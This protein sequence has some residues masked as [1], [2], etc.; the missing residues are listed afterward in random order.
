MPELVYVNYKG[1]DLNKHVYEFL[2]SETPEVVYG[3]W[4]LYPNPSICGDISPDP[5]TYSIVKTVKTDY[6][7]KTIQE[8]SC[9]SMEYAMN[10]VVA[11]AWIDIEGLDVYPPNGRMVF[12]YGD[13]MEKVIEL[14]GSYEYHFE[15]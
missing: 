10:G 4:W 12:H 3:P 6:R 9:F 5:T 7:L 15:E 2:F 13:S 8:N 1:D 11:L 14:L